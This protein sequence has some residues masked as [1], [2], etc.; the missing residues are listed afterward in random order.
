L[1]ARDDGAVVTAVTLTEVQR[2][3]PG[4]THG[5]ASAALLDEVMGAAVW[6]AGYQVAAGNLEVEYRRP[7]PLG[8]RS[9]S[10]EEWLKYV[11]QLR[12]PCVERAK[13]LTTVEMGEKC[14]KALLVHVDDSARPLS[15]HTTKKRH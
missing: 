10:R 4:H 13:L 6:R 12:I 9:T 3:P 7:V 14:Q 11:M 2:G 8:S 1:W 15:A 5:G